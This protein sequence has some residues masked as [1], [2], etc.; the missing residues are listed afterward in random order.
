MYVLF[1]LV[2]FLV[3]AMMIIWLCICICIS[4]RTCIEQYHE[5]WWACYDAATKK[6]AVAV[7]PIEATEV[8]YLGGIEIE[9]E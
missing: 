7:H 8:T 4:C 3:G 9:N 2:L 6:R 1:M 5:T